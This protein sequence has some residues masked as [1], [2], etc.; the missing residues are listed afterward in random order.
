MAKK[1]KKSFIQIIIFIVIMI[2]V[3]Y[4]NKDRLGTNVSKIDDLM[5]SNNGPVLEDDQTG[6][7]RAEKL[8]IEKVLAENKKFLQNDDGFLDNLD[9]YINLPMTEDEY[10]SFIGKVHNDYPFGNPISEIK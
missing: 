6:K 9:S 5:I 2:A 8:R 10:K 7:I 1:G 4:L 3:L